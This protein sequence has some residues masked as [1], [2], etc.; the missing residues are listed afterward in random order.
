MV[1]LRQDIGNDGQSHDAR[2]SDDAGRDSV[3]E[4]VI[5]KAPQS[6]ELCRLRQLLRSITCFL[7]QSNV[8][9]VASKRGDTSR[10]S[11]HIVAHALQQLARL[12]F[13]DLALLLITAI[14][15][16]VHKLHRI[17]A[18]ELNL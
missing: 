7:L 16:Q 17:L 11:V 5:L 13:D 12:G 2:L 6:T 9:C 8:E 1:F 3:E 18:D 15:G 10:R 14:Q 4:G